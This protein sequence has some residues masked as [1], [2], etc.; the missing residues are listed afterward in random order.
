V[1]SVVLT[2]EPTVA[3]LRS[4]FYRLTFLSL[5]ARL[6]TVNNT[7]L[8]RVLYIPVYVYLVYES[9]YYVAS[10]SCLVAL[11]SSLSGTDEVSS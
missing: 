4:E 6:N 9:K 3:T 10:A 5:T 7:T 11:R 8:Y 2:L 1:L